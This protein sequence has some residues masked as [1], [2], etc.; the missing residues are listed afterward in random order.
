MYNSTRET[1][2]LCKK[3]RA[4]D[5]SMP[6]VSSSLVFH[7]LGFWLRTFSVGDSQKPQKLPLPIGSKFKTWKKWFSQGKSHGKQV[8]A[9][10]MCPYQFWFFGINSHNSVLIAGRQKV[11]DAIVCDVKFLLTVII[12]PALHILVKRR[13]KY[14]SSLETTKLSVCGLEKQWNLKCLVY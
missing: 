9:L 1:Y 12:L 11:A 5:S 10:S 3:V 14:G 7:E 6:A 8:Y 4:Q 2:Y 13:T